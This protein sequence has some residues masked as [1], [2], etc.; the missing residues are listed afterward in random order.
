MLKIKLPDDIGKVEISKILMII[1]CQEMQFM[2]NFL[3]WHTFE[4]NFGMSSS[5]NSQTIWRRVG[6][7][8]YMNNP[9]LIIFY[10]FFLLER[11]HQKVRLFWLSQA[12]IGL[13]I[14]LELMLNFLVQIKSV[15]WHFLKKTHYQGKHMIRFLSK[16]FY[17][18]WKV[19]Y[20]PW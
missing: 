13:F 6:D 7:R 9:S 10:I 2:N 11:Y 5:I 17:V 1:W 8:V 14:S 16:V 12:W 3:T 18:W 15:R 20:L 4:N 19:P